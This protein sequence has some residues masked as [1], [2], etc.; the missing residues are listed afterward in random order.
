VLGKSTSML[1]IQQLLS[2]SILL[3]RGYYF[4]SVL[5]NQDILK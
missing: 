1:L 5:D 4:S 2:L 3:K